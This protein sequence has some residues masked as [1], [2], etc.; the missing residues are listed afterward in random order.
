M[1]RFPTYVS[2]NRPVGGWIGAERE[3]EVDL[4][5]EEGDEG[6]EQRRRLQQAVAQGREGGSVAVPEA[7]AREPDV[8]VGELLDVLGD[9]AA[10]GGAVEL[11]HVGAHRRGRR[12]QARERPAVEVL[13]HVQLFLCLAIRGKGTAREL[14]GSKSAGPRLLGVGVEDPEGVGVP[15]GE[16]ELA[17]RFADRVDREAV[18][19]PGLL[20]GQVVPAEGVGAVGGD[21]LPGVDDVAAALRHLLALGVEDQAEADAVAVAGLSE[22]EG[23]LGQ[24]RV[25]PA[26]GL[27]LGLADV[28]GREALLELVLVLERVVE[29]GEGH[30]AAVVPGVDHRLDPAH[31][32][33]ALAA[34]DRHLV[35]VG[36]VEVVGDRAAGALAQLGDRADALELAA[37]AVG[38]A[39]DR[40]R[41]APVAVAGERPVDVVLQPFAEAAVLDVLG[42]PADRL[43]V[44]KHLLLHLGGARC[45]SSRSRSRAAACRSASSAGRS[46]RR[47]ARGRAGRGARGR[48]SAR[49]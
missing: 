6:S 21:D 25:E 47:P 35:D 28:V 30:R 31:L 9:G 14:A 16:E 7:P 41:R 34:L 29:L 40:Q 4:V 10:G 15:E 38:A 23:R 44:G 42:V 22:E 12:L 1:G 26:A 33:A 43:V 19:G 45:T 32:A 48:R 11:V 3:V 5:G 2:G 17:D 20:R 24:Q 18:A 39:P 27:V 37:A 36:A 13:S 8:P 49:G 46:A